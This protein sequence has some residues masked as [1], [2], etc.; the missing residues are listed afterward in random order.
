MADPAGAGQSTTVI[1][2]QSA[3]IS[4]LTELNYEDIITNLSNWLLSGGAGN[5]FATTVNPSR[6]PSPGRSRSSW[7]SSLRSWRCS[8][9]SG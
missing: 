5:I 7:R 3:S 9:R 8:A 1:D 4:G 6:R 2:R